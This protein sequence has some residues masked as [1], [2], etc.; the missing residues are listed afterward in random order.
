APPAPAPEPPALVRPAYVAALVIAIGLG[1]R[2]WLAASLDLQKDEVTYWAWSQHLDAAFAFLPLAAIRISCAL[3]GDTAWAVRLPFLLAATG[4]A[5][6]AW[7]FARAAGA[8]GTIAAWTVAIFSVNLWFHFAGAQAHPDAFLAFFWMASLTALARSTREESKNRTAWLYAGAA[9]AAGAATSKYT[10]FFLWPGW[11]LAEFLAGSGRAHPWR[12]SGIASIFWIALAAPAIAAIAAT[13]GEPVRMA[14]ALSDLGDRLSPAA[15]LMALPAAP[16]LVLLSPTYAVWAAGLIR[17]A[18][19]QGGPDARY[20]RLT[21]PTAAALVAI[22]LKGSVK[23]NWSLPA[24]WGTIH[25][26]VSWLRSSKVGRRLLWAFTLTGAVVTIGLQAALLNPERF[27]GGLESLPRF[28]PLDSTYAWTASA[29]EL[30]HASARRWSDR[31]YEVHGQRATAEST[32]VRAAAWGGGAVVMSDLYEVVYRTKFYD[33]RRP[34]LLVGDLRMSQ[35]PEHRAAGQALPER[36]IYV[37]QPGAKLPEEFFLTYGL[38]ERERRLVVPLGNP[39]AFIGPR[40][41]G[42]VDT[43]NARRYDVWRCAKGREP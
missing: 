35:V 25:A 18:R 17:A 1:L 4:A 28:A 15:R 42:P 27:I 21:M 7:T 30:E 34:T 43:R 14:L 3:F 37:T 29:E 12:Q 40:L 32:A 16:L 41:E 13:D 5:I 39:T 9:L 22:A 33:R 11:L 26:G 19:A 23:G 10:G 20:A 6:G 2:A 38:L 24:F 36:A 8:P 31:L